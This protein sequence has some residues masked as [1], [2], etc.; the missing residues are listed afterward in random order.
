MYRFVPLG[1]DDDAQ[2]SIHKGICPWFTPLVSSNYFAMTI[3]SP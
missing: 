1:T 2:G 3:A